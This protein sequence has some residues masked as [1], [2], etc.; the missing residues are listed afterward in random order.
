MHSKYKKFAFINEN[1]YNFKNK[2][3][4]HYINLL[5]LLSIY[6]FEFYQIIKI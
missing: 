6:N 2:S 4:L 1:N 3:N 5:Y